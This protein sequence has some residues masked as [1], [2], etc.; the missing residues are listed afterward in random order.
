MKYR[1]KSEPFRVMGKR[2][3]VMRDSDGKYWVK[4]GASITQRKLNSSKIVNYLI[5]CCQVNRAIDKL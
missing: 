3:M 2:I 5:N 4:C 1:W